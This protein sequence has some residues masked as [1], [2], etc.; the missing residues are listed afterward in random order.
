MKVRASLRST[1]EKTYPSIRFRIDFGPKSAVGPGKIELLEQIEHS[2]SLSQAARNLNMSYRRAWQLMDSLNS[3][4]VE[5]V[6][7]TSKG[8]RRGGGAKLSLLGERL[9]HVYRIFETKIQARAAESFRPFR[10]RV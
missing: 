10:V 2:G 1:P 6:V 7:I 4:F 9:I 8:G 5:P 3:C